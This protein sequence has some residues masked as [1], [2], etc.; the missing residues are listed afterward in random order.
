MMLHTTILHDQDSEDDFNALDETTGAKPKAENEGLPD[1]SMNR[2]K[3]ASN[4]KLLEQLIGKR[5][6]AERKKQQERESLRSRGRGGA[7]AILNATR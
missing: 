7:D 3:L 4:E 5:A 6:V 2:R 1:G